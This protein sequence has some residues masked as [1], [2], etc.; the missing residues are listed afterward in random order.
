MKKE[1]LYSTLI[2]LFLVILPQGFAFEFPEESDVRGAQIN[3]NI[4]W[5]RFFQASR[6][7]IIGGNRTILISAEQPYEFQTTNRTVHFFTVSSMASSYVALEFYSIPDT[8]ELFEGQSTFIHSKTHTY[9]FRLRS[10]DNLLANIQ[11]LVYERTAE[12]PRAEIHEESSSNETIQSEIEEQAQNETQD[13]FNEPPEPIDD[14]NWTLIIALLSLIPLLG[15]YVFI[16]IKQKKKTKGHLPETEIKNSPKQKK[17]KAFSGFKLKNTKKT[18]AKPQDTIDTSKKIFEDNA[19][20]TETLQKEHN[21]DSTHRETNQ[22]DNNNNSGN[23][24][25]ETMNPNTD[26]NTITSDNENNNNNKEQETNTNQD[27]SPPQT[28]EQPTPKEENLEQKERPISTQN[29]SSFSEYQRLKKQLEEDI[30][31][32]KHNSKKK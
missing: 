7:R 29:I 8:I 4:I 27:S 6:Q 26:N 18:V 22:M 19:K 24:N 16:K 32:A 15:A 28:E 9:E 11:L 21:K 30:E 25:Q 20:D 23:N 1:V 31:A 14:T 10:V 5:D 12:I 3:N 17:F 13:L 2:V